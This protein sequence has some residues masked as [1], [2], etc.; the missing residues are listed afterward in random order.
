MQL[1]IGRT[2]LQ[3]GAYIFVVV[4][5]YVLGSTPAGYIAGRARGIDVRTMGSGNIGA[6]N[7]FRVMGRTAGIAVLAADALKGFVAARCAPLLALYLF[8]NCGAQRE[9]LA[10]AAGVAAILGHNY[11]FWLRFKGGK[12]IATTGGVVMAW[13]PQACLTALALWGVVLAVTRYVSAAS[14]AAAIILPFAVWFFNG[15]VTMTCAMTGL[16][17]LAIYKHKGNIQ[18]LLKGTENRIGKAKN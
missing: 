5:S 1:E 9:D 13:A 14:I 7:V 2:R 10:L 4:V 17:L 11:S 6:T 18:R 15:S 3:I 8:P 12:G 16:S